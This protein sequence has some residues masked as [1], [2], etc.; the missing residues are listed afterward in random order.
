MGNISGNQDKPRFISLASKE[1]SP[2]EDTKLAGYVR[3][4]G[5]KTSPYAYSKLALLHAFN[6]AIPGV[7]IIYYGDEFG[8]PGA[9]D[10]DNRRMM[11]FDGY[12][13]EE[14]NL[15][16]LVRQ[17]VQARRKHM[18]LNYGNTEIISL[19][20]SVIN[21]KRSYLNEHIEIILN[22]SELPFTVKIDSKARVI[23]GNSNLGISQVTV[24][25]FGF[26]YLLT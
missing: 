4:I 26:V 12:S 17:I 5:T 7:P 23:A 24:P 20:K 8:M 3:Q 6:H 16:I 1:V 15:K 22:N 25:A 11:K 19:N 10:P 21:I 2:N 18:A 14:M 9:N 13:P